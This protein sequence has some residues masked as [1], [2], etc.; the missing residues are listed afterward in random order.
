[1]WSPWISVSD[2][3]SWAMVPSSAAEI[4]PVEI[5]PA[6][7]GPVE[8]GPAEIGLVEID[9]AEIGPVEIGPAGEVV[10]GRPSSALREPVQRAQR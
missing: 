7:I 8:I 6:E 1:M 4:G 3:N 9:L 5:G 2:P 10:S